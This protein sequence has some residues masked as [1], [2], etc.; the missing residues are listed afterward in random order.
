VPS[1]K[2]G[3]LVE[4]LTALDWHA[5][6]EDRQADLVL[7]RFAE[8]P[9]PAPLGQCRAAIDRCFGEPTVEAILAAIERECT[10]WADETR[11]A[12]LRMSPTSLKVTHRQMRQGR[13]YDVE[14]AL[15]LEYRLTQ[16]FMEESDF[17]EGV[18]AVLVDKDQAPRWDPARLEEVSEERVARHFRD[19][20]ADELTFIE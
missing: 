17:F 6:A 8:N 2:L 19:L 13:D 1:A 5:G 9:G 7:T 14:R 11:A 20:G 16:H 3:A 12:L 4:A 10:P 18:R 15:V